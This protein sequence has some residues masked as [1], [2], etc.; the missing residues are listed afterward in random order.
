L[1]AKD[2]KV[3]VEIL[4]VTEITTYPSPGKPAKTHVVSYR[5]PGMIFGSVFIPADQDKPDVRA[6]MIREDL[7]KKLARKTEK[8]R[9]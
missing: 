2:Q 7:E 9:V 1:S 5:G 8:L 3:E 6:R 4:D